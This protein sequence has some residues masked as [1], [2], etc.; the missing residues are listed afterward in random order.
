MFYI[1]MKLLNIVGFLS[2]TNHS[3]DSTLIDLGSTTVILNL[4]YAVAIYTVCCVG[5]TSNH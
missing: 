2:G 1:G 3:L 5:V 4:S